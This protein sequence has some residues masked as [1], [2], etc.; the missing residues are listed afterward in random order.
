MFLLYIYIYIHIYTHANVYMWIYHIELCMY[1]HMYIYI[2]LSIYHNRA[3]LLHETESRDTKPR[4]LYKPL[5]LQPE[6]K[7]QSL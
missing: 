7:T 3:F 2:Y 5:A 6:H 4:A 1:I